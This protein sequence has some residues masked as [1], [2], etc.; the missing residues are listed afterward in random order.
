MTGQFKVV[1]THSYKYYPIRF[2][3]PQQQ[4]ITSQRSYEQTSA[5]YIGRLVN[6]EFEMK[7]TVVV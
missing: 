5:Y 2:K 6:N 4:M 7:E 3:I 1:S